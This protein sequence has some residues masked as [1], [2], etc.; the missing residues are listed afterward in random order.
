MCIQNAVMGIVKKS[1]RIF[2]KSP[3]ALIALI[4]L[5]LFLTCGELDT[6]LP[7]TGTY[8]VNALINNTSL[9][10]SSLIAKNDRI[11]PYFASSVTGD[12]DIRGLLVFLQ[13][14]SGE[15]VGKKIHYT[16]NPAKEKTEEDKPDTKTRE[17]EKKDPVSDDKNTVTAEKDQ[18]TGSVTT[19]N[20]ETEILIHVQRL[21]KDLPSFSLPGT[22]RI[23]QYTLVF[24]ILGEREILDQIEKN[25]YYLDDAV[26]S[27][28]DIQRYLPDVSNGSYLI[29]P[30]ITIMLEVKVAADKRLDPYIIWYNGKKRISEGQ[31]SGGAGLILWK[32]PEQTGFHTVRV[33]AFPYHPATGVYGQSRE[34]SFPISSKAADTG[35]FSGEADR[36][37][38]WYQFRGNL[39]DSKTPVA[40]ERAL[41]PRSERPSQWTPQDNIYG[42]TV[43]SKDIYLLPAFPVIP[44]GETRGGGQF[45]FRFKPVSEGT[46]FSV[47]FKSESASGPVYMDLA[48]S[49]K[50]L[51]LNID[52]PGT[53]EVMPVAYASEDGEGFITLIVDFLIDKN[54]LTVKLDRENGGP[55]PPEPKEIV[56]PS[57]LNGEGS[58]QFGASLKDTGRKDEKTSVP[59]GERPIPPE[60]AIIDEFAF[61]RMDASPL[62]GEPDEILEPGSETNPNPMLSDETDSTTVLR[63]SAGEEPFFN[64]DTVIPLSFEKER[65][66]NSKPAF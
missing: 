63:E 11:F 47:L 44:S 54:H 59:D 62:S 55:V 20:E 14:P 38:H 30:G 45:M 52:T 3:I 29:P 57:P 1:G 25:V 7:S 56:L 2:R 46:V 43:G 32:V 49:K 12:P 51:N 53:S 61:A 33:E 66:P 64:G 34:I 40:T 23:G 27:L 58:F 9:N 5:S 50:T 17:T 31:V 8:Q 15:T 39:Q 42:L 19:E 36:I 41:I 18:I 21:D 10:E 13:D 65:P 4:I 24:Q 16:L 37:T 60:T 48:L 22:L 26:F 28:T 35:Y 6:V